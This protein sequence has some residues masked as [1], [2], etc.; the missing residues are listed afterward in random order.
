[1]SHIL[2]IDDYINFLENFSCHI[3]EYS[4]MIL[5][6][7]K[8]QDDEYYD[9]NYAKE[10]NEFYNSKIESIANQIEI[11]QN[12]EIDNFESTGIIVKKMDNNIKSKLLDLI[13]NYANRTEFDYH[14]GSGDRVRDIV[15]P[16]LYPFIFK[17]KQKFFKL[18]FW[19]R[20][21]EN[22]KYQWL[23]SEFQIDENGGC[24][25]VSY[26][27]NLP[28]YEVELYSAIEKLFEILLP[29]FEKSVSYANSIKIFENEEDLREN[30]KR[31]IDE[32]SLKNRT[33]QVITKIVQVSLNP[34]DKLPGSWHVEGMSHENIIST[35]SCTIDK[36]KDF[37]ANLYFKRTYYEEEA[38]KL[39]MVTQQYPPEEIENL[40]HNNLVPIGKTSIKDG[41]VVVF[42]NNMVH[43]IDMENNSSEKQTRTILVF[44][45]INPDIKIKSTKDIPQ[46]NYDVELAKKNRLE[47]MKERTYYK[48]NFNQRKI[49]L[50]EH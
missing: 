46:Q 2:V 24:K 28:L 30:P 8:Y 10:I 27:N 17:K 7:P 3:S 16:S 38:G 42:P 25:I 26:I 18:D 39:V 21:Y 29:D 9:N 11:F 45:L 33:L 35:A 6:D 34:N 22:S 12:R 13:N 50:C 37:E 44:W 31:I 4:S 48:Q 14:P 32:I 23:P 40:Y 5:N 43:K 1:M 36:P 15:H 19:K 49:N 47:L 20:P 41:S